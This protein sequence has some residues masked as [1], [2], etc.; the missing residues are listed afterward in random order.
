M[1]PRPVVRD[2]TVSAGASDAPDA[3]ERRRFRRVEADLGLRYLVGEAEAAGRL[4][5]VSAGGARVEAETAPPKGQRVV[6]YVD[7][8]GRLEGEV[9]RRTP[10]GFA[11]RLTHRLGRAKRL[12]DALTWI[13][14][15][16]A[17]RDRRRARRYPQDKPARMV[18]A[19]GTAHACRILDISTTGASVGLAD[20]HRPAIGETV[21]LGLM[22]ARVVRH[23]ADGI[24]VLF[25]EPQPVPP[26][27]LPSGA[28]HARD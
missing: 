27:P 15:R 6:L 13:A 7:R 24:G 23:H 3:D 2:I 11:L 26:S 10:T 20:Q 14:N 4:G 19:D 28:R 5:D 12:A 8:L 9:V 22:G 18:R 21:T 16:P 1:P 17:S 25:D